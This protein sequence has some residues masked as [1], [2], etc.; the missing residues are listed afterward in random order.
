MEFVPWIAL[1]CR[2][3]RSDENLWY[4]LT[5]PVAVSAAIFMHLTQCTGSPGVAKRLSRRE[6]QAQAKATP[7][8]SDQRWT[9]RGLYT[10]I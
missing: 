4:H 2:K 5:S 7:D 9:F 10:V 3:C 8:M 1:T 6:L